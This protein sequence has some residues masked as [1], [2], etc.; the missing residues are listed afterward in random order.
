MKAGIS[1]CACLAIISD[2]TLA[3]LIFDLRTPSD[4]KDSLEPFST[5]SSSPQHRARDLVS[6]QICQNYHFRQINASQGE[7]YSEFNTA[8]L[9]DIKI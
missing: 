6:F 1:D 9:F 4:I 7:A 3:S 5:D 2:W 8:F